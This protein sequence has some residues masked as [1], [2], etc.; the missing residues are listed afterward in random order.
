[1]QEFLNANSEWV[2]EYAIPWGINIVTAIAIYI[3]GRF[4]SKLIIKSLLK[5]MERANVDLS[6]RGFI[7]NILNVVLLVVIVIAALEQLGV[8][9]T[10][11]LAV[12]AAAGLAV[13]L[14]L[15]DSLSNFA[16]G[17]ML[18]IFKPFKVG[19]VIDTA[20]KIGKVQSIQIF[21]TVLRTGDNQEIIIPNSQVYGGSITNITACDTR[22]IDLVIGIGYDDD[23]KKA[24]TIIETI[25]GNNAS[26]LKDPE[27]TIMVLELGESSIDIAV[28]PWVNASDYWAVRAYLLQSIKE[29]FDENGISIPYPQRDL[30]LIQSDATALAT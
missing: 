13:G 26:I 10:S 23:I 21:N 6:L 18:I 5:V 7:G 19:D 4:I 1:M 3:I 28:R 8:D 17:V 15:K 29:T 11:V 12:F 27:P 20:G 24:K 2:S 14:A 25:I 30:H 16:A 9:T 22:R